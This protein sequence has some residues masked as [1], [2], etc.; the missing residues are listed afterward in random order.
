MS[1]NLIPIK[2]YLG[3]FYTELN[4]TVLTSQ[5][6][7]N[8]N[9][10]TFFEQRFHIQ[11]NKVQMIVDVHLKGL[12]AI[13][14]G[15][16]IH[17][18]KELYKHPAIDI[19]NSIEEKGPDPKSLYSTRTF[20]TI[21]YLICQNHTLFKVLRD[22]DEPIYISFKSDYEC[23]YNSVLL[24]M[25]S[26]GA[27]VNIV[28]EVESHCAINSV[29]NYILNPYSVLNV[30]TFYKN[31]KPTVSFFFRNVIAQTHSTYNHLLLGKGSANV[32]DENRIV[33]ETGSNLELNG[34]ID[35]VGNSF[36]SIIEATSVHDD[37]SITI[38]YKSSAK[39][40]GKVTI[41]PVI[42]ISGLTSTDV[43]IQN[44]IVDEMS[45]IIT[46]PSVNAHE[47][48]DMTNSDISDFIIEPTELEQLLAE[49]ME[50]G[51]A[52][53]LLTSRFSEDI[54]EKIGISSTKGTSLYYEMK[55]KFLG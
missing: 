3:K 15:N 7:K 13:V 43:S 11:D 25:I 29:V 5:K 16:E 21:A 27:T 47:S 32:V 18:S 2:T 28:E 38:N 42:E 55:N 54:A 35:A 8:T 37:N 30:S 33:F 6:Y 19:T 50:E 49:G 17:V 12:R 45:S 48:T 31:Q 4:N 34:K 39:D 20:S 44:L 26:T 10:N 14:S 36:H 51:K 23:F 52:I 22:I 41:T 9:I 53:Q 40:K 24:F 46:T 1:P